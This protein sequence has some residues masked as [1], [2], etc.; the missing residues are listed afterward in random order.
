ME[1][2]KDKSSFDPSGWNEYSKEE[3]E[4]LVLLYLQDYYKSLDDYFLQEAFQIAKDEGVD[5]HKL[6]RQ[7][8]DLLN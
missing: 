6:M 7:A 8:R 1:S 5:I 2:S 4:Q 3:S